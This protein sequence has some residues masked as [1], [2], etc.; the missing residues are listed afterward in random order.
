LTPHQA[1]ALRELFEEGGVWLG[2]T[3]PSPVE[4]EQLLRRQTTVADLVARYPVET[5]ALQPAGLRTTP[6]YSPVRYAAQF[7]LALTESEPRIW[8]AELLDGAWWAPAEAYAAWQR[9]DILLAPPTLEAVRQLREGAGAALPVLQREQSYPPV[10]PLSPG[11]GYLPLETATLPP[12]RHTLCLFIGGER[13]LLVDPATPLPAAAL[14]GREIEEVVFTHHHSDHI[15]GWE[16]ARARGLR[17]AAH[18]ET[19]R[20]L[21]FTVD[22]EVEDG[23]TWDLGLDGAGLPWHVRALHTPGH[24]PGHL[25]LWEA[26]R[27]FLLAGDLVSGVSTILI[28]PEEGDM[29]AYLAS[30]K[31]MASLEPQLVVASHGPPFGPGAAIFERVLEHRLAREARLLQCLGAE[32]QPVESLTAEVYADTP[33]AH[34][35]LARRSLLAHLKKLVQEGRAREEEGGYSLSC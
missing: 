22:R 15:G 25:A 35:E 13:Q 23:E 1:C 29:A 33:K 34:P 3:P 10:L 30:L 32:P 24:A 8:E 16:W 28:D 17:L 26:R 20:R 18:P 14:E 2:A 5:A 19:A 4:R 21:P 27:R 31:R 9:G 6:V 12:A 11:L 7:Y